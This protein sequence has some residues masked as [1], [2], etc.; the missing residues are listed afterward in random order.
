MNSHQHVEEVVNP[1]WDETNIIQEYHNE[2]SSQESIIILD[3][4]LQ[5]E[6]AT[7]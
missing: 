7:E 5:E 4:L 1:N 3:V 2:Q 6:E